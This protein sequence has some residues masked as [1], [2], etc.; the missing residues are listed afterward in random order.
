MKTC[1]TSFIIREKNQIKTTMSY[2]LR[3]VRMADIKVLQAINA[4]EGV[5]KKESSY[6]VGGKAN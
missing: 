5:E 6:S 2:H 3:P 1:P 4:G